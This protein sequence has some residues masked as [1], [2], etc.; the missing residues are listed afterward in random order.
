MPPTEQD[1]QNAVEVLGALRFFPSDS[2]SRIGIK[3]VLR[4]MV[5]EEKQLDWL[6]NTMLNQVGEWRGTVDLRG[7]YCTRFKPAEGLEATTSTAGFSQDDL[8]AES[9]TKHLEQA[10]R[11][12]D[13]RSI[14]HLKLP[15]VQ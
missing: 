7:I 15:P 6:I 8:E 3:H 2:G 1:L 9:S 13:L 10:P 12:G 11:A 4:S 14:K 5:G